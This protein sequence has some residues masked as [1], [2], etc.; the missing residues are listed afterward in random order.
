VQT[1]V[2]SVSG[3]L[4]EQVLVLLGRAG[5]ARGASHELRAGLFEWCIAFAAMPALEL[6]ES[7]DTS[8][9]RIQTC[10]ALATQAPSHWT[11]ILGFAS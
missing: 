5:A 8:A 1:V 11:P 6:A 3:E 7:P 10:L 2:G 4:G 9:D